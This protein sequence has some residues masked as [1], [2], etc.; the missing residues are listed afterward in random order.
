MAAAASEEK[1]EKSSGGAPKLHADLQKALDSIR[2]ERAFD[3]DAWIT[4]KCTL[5]NDY[6][7]K[8]GLKGC[9]VNLSGGVDSAVTLGLMQRAASQKD[10]PITKVLAISQPIHSSAWAFNR[11]DECAKAFKAELVTFDQT[12]VYD[13]LKKLID[14]QLSIEGNAFAAGQLRSY[15]RTPSVYYAAQ[16]LSSQ[17]TPTVVMGT[18]N[19]DEDGYLAYFCKAGDGVVDV[20]LI[21]DLHKSEV[22][23]VGAKLGV[24]DSILL[25][26]PSADLWDAQTDEEELG[27]PYDF[28]E[29]WTTILD[30]TGDDGS[31]AGK[32]KAEVEKAAGAAVGD[33]AWAQFQE[34]GKKAVQIHRR[35]QHKLN[36]P[37][38]L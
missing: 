5:F 15:L 6:M 20:Q 36:S 2:K 25:A 7:R 26:A 10:S 3:A 30:R 21:A 27:F 18:G 32:L 33:E 35:N 9:I 29:L 19:K 31:D 8:C 16:L 38:N 1:Q 23:T 28:I 24:P 13:A 37:I 22:F 17:G 14:A 12:A 11:A 4:K 34:W